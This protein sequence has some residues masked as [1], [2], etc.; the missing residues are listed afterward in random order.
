MRFN[1]KLIFAIG[2]NN[3]SDEGSSDF[4]NNIL[5]QSEVFLN[6]IKYNNTQSIESDS[7]AE[8]VES[9][10]NRIRE[11]TS[12]TTSSKVISSTSTP[13]NAIKR[14]RS[15]DNSNE[16]SGGKGK[17]EYSS[18][19]NKNKF[20]FF[21]SVPEPSL[22]KTIEKCHIHNTA[23]TTS[24]KQRKLCSETIAPSKQPIK[25]V[26]SN[27]N[28]RHH[29]I[30]HSHSTSSSSASKQHQQSRRNSDYYGSSVDIRMIDFA[31]TAFV[32]KNSSCLVPS[33]TTI[34]HGPDGGFLTGL[35]SL[36]RLLTEILTEE[37]L[38]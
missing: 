25:S 19:M 35:D 24:N 23:M 16:K 7:A 27:I 26:S 31:H 38:N 3:S 12:S 22:S 18:I 5:E 10:T 4:D 37:K 15:R 13:T 6:S 2:G 33:L 30:S 34:H 21:S 20:I 36:N 17:N 29:R 14:L 1:Y 28:N 8:L 32:P 11:R 9:G